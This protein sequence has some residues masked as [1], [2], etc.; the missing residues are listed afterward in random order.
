M[1]LLHMHHRL[2]LNQPLK[3][4]Y[5]SNIIGTAF[6]IFN[7]FLLGRLHHVFDRDENGTVRKL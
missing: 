1:A 6:N 4:R 3:G 7:N 5:F 2:T